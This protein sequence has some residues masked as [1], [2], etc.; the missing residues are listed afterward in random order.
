GSIYLLKW[1]YV[2]G[3]CRNCV[4]GTADIGCCHAAA[5]AQS[6]AVALA[7][8]ASLAVIRVG[9]TN[10]QPV[11]HRSTLQVDSFD[12]S[13]PSFLVSRYTPRKSLKTSHMSPWSSRA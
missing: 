13:P 4:L 1:I 7:E 10:Y 2:R 12:I 3:N 6:V 8:P 9:T 5:V 11:P